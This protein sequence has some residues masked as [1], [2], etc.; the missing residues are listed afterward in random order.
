V[1][2]DERRLHELVLGRRL[3]QLELQETDAVGGNTSTSSGASATF[4]YSGFDNSASE[5]FGLYWWTASAI[6]SRSKRFERSI[7]T[8]W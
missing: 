4:T 8:P 5:Y 7:A 1:G 2:D 6:V 3:E